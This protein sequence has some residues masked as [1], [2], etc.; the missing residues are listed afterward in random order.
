M[1]KSISKDTRTVSV[2]S[3][4]GVRFFQSPSMSD[5]QTI[6]PSSYR[7]FFLALSS[8]VLISLSL[9]S[10]PLAA[11]ASYEIVWIA[12]SQWTHTMRVVMHEGHMAERVQYN[13]T[14]R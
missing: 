2:D 13:Y 10:L 3:G 12:V 8:F 9:F 4:S 11:Y 7:L 1:P 5:C 6:S 14:T